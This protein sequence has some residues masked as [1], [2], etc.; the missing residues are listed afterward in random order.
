[1]AGREFIFK[2]QLGPRSEFYVPSYY[3]A[4]RPTISSNPTV[5]NYGGTINIPTPNAA[6]IGKVSLIRLS[7]FTHGFNSDLRFIWL[8]IGSKGSSSVTVSAPVNANCT[9]WLLYDPC[10][11]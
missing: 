1:M 5:G 9:S 11:K 4:T 3:N 8:Q 6:G 10:S 7:T 2:K